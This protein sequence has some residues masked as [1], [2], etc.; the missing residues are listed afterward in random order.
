M[1]NFIKN[2][3]KNLFGGNKPETPPDF[4][5]YQKGVRPTDYQSMYDTMIVNSVHLEFIHSKI[6]TKIFQNKARYESVSAICGVPWEV[7]ACIHSLEASLS[8]STHLHNGD[9]L[10]RRTVNVPSGR[11]VHGEPPFAW[12]TSCLDAIRYDG[13]DMNKDWSVNGVGYCFE[14]FNGWGYRKRGLVSPYLWS[15]SS[16]YKRGKYVSDGRYDPDAVSQQCGAMV[17][18]KLLRDGDA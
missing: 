13:L 7:I 5:S 2:L 1:W 18:Y 16:H 12:E 9:P 3:V 4:T 8:F 14:K 10:S 15:F 6:L 11:P 17:L